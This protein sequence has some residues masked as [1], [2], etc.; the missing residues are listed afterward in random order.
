MSARTFIYTVHTRSGIRFLIEADNLTQAE[1]RARD[2]VIAR[3][4]TAML[5]QAL[6]EIE[7]IEPYRGPQH[8]A[9]RKL[10]FKT[11]AFSR[12]AQPPSHTAKHSG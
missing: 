7:R 12:R 10:L 5:R 2:P 9:E 6:S 4:L 8:L 3:T 1:I 11:D